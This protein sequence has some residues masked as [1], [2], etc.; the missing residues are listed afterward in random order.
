MP[1]IVQQT[2]MGTASSIERASAAGAVAVFVEVV[3]ITGATVGFGA[4]TVRSGC[5][6]AIFTAEAG[7]RLG[8]GRMLMRAVSFFGPD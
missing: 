6:F 2:G 8:S 4:G 3:T 1:K 5:V 7:G